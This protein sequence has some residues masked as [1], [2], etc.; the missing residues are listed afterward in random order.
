MW[1]DLSAMRIPNLAVMLLAGVFLA[2]GLL[3]L[4]LPTYGWR[5]VTM[6]AVLVLGFLANAAGLM[7]AGDSK[8]IAAA[9][10]FIDPG[11]GAVLAS[12]SRRTCWPVSPPTGWPSTARCAASPPAGRAGRAAASSPW[13]SRWP[14]RC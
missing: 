8:F 14:A 5:V 6:L 12:S 9:A 3:A 2:V 7:G 13:A 10:P 1:S 4:P 11:D